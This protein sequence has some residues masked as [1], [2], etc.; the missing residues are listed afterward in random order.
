MKQ[1][2][3]LFQFSLFV[4]MVFLANPIFSQ[5]SAPKATFESLTNYNDPAEEED[6]I[7]TFCDNIGLGAGELV[8]NSADGSGGWTFTWTKWNPNTLDFT[9]P[10]TVETNQSVSTLNN[11]TDGLYRVMLSR[12]GEVD[13]SVE[14]WV[15]NRVSNGVQP[16][17]VRDRRECAGVYFLGT[18][19]NQL[20]YRDITTV[21]EISLFTNYVF[22]LFR[23]SSSVQR[24]PVSNYDGGSNTFYDG[25]VFEGVEDYY[26]VVEDECGNKYTSEIVYSDTYSISAEF[27]VEPMEG[28]APLEVSFQLTNS[29]NIHS[30]EWFIYQDFDRLETALTSVE[31]SLL[32]DGVLVDE[33][34]APYTYMHPGNYFVKLIASSNKGP[35]TC[36]EEFYLKTEGT[37]IVVDTSLVQVPNVFTPNGDGRNDVFRVKSQSLKTFHAVLLNR[38]GRVVYE[39]K[40]PDEG[41]NGKINGKWATPGTY[42]YVITATGREELKKKYTKKG[43]FMLIRK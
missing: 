11:L 27:S 3:K 9:I 28:E 43:S 36:I 4:I 42:F 24:T 25:E 32:I 1:S 30:Y 14:A 8:A 16:N 22:E 33:D 10:V 34:P 13:H 40:N 38:W 18:L 6:L 39:W 21:S 41:W 2:I 17:L 20:K 29:A 37:P 5:I 15:L 26:I 35:E 31:D 19:S 23:G 12:S 7:F